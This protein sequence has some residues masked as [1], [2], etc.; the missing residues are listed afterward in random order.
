MGS[1][2]TRKTNR[3]L[4]GIGFG[5]KWF[6]HFA[7]QWRD[8]IIPGHFRPNRASPDNRFGFLVGPPPICYFRRSVILRPS[9]TLKKFS[10][11]WQFLVPRHRRGAMFPKHFRP[12]ILCRFRDNLCQNWFCHLPP[13]HCLYDVIH[14]VA[15][16]RPGSG[17]HMATDVFSRA[18]AASSDHRNLRD[19][20]L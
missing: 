2:P 7:P 19:S 10:S 3:F 4:G 1:G 13:C 16:R 17:R 14:R 5:Q 9:I 11:W 8:V 15:D 20:W 18:K 6:S 12:A